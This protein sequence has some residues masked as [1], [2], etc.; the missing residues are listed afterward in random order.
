MAMLVK[1]LLASKKYTV[2]GYG[3]SNSEGIRIL[4]LCDAADLVVVNTH[5]TK[6]DSRLVTYIITQVDYILVKSNNFKL[7][8]DVKIIG[9][10]NV[11]H[12][13]SVISN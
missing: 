2:G 8:C 6:S 12:N 7:A 4:Q 1:L 5:F 10:E 9:S 13:M 11:F 3:V